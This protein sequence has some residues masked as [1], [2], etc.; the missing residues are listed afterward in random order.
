MSNL[1]FL[2][3][4]MYLMPIFLMVV[5]LVLHRKTGKAS[6]FAGHNE[7]FTRTVDYTGGAIGVQIGSAVLAVYGHPFLSFLLFAVAAIIWYAY[8]KPIWADYQAAV[9][10]K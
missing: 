3:M 1:S 4:V 10:G 9:I 7:M 6:R 5:G 8:F 2:N